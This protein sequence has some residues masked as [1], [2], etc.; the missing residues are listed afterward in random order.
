M[1]NREQSSGEF[2]EVASNTSM[3]LRLCHA[4]TQS[5]AESKTWYRK[6]TQSGARV[7]Q[8]VPDSNLKS[9]MFAILR[10]VG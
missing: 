3:R 10:N 5:R 2:A 1:A 6:H 7:C 9:W 4:L 8:L